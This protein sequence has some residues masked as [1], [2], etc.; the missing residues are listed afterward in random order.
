MYLCFYPWRGVYVR[1]DQPN[2]SPF[3]FEIPTQ[4]HIT[5][6]EWIDHEAG[7]HAVKGYLS[8]SMGDAP[9]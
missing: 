8:L 1:R 9:A 2:T 4:S 3:I 6:A 7:G 5:G